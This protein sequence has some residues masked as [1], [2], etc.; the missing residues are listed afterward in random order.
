M[1]LEFNIVDDME[2][3]DFTVSGFYRSRQPDE[4]YVDYPYILCLRR[5]IEHRQQPVSN[6][7]VQQDTVTWHV[8]VTDLQAAGVSPKFRDRIIDEYDVQWW[9]ESYSTETLGT[10]YKMKCNKVKVAVGSPVDG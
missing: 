1:P 7:R 4:S 3:F 9:V 6:A 5:A 2:V 8:K 10:R